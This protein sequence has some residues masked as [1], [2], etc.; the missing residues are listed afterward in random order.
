[1]R[2]DDCDDILREPRKQLGDVL[3]IIGIEH[4][5]FFAVV[6]LIEEGGYPPQNGFLVH[7]SSAGVG[8][9]AV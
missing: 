3:E 5:K 9:A 1:M 6:A 2:P 7:D 4:D 8:G